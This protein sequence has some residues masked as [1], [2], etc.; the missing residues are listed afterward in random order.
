M[1]YLLLCFQLSL[2]NEFLF[3]SITNVAESMQNI[4]ENFCNILESR[5]S[6]QV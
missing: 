1:L 4:Q 3:F 5:T 6:G 2:K